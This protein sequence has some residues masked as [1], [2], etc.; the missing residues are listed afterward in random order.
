MQSLLKLTREDVQRSKLFSSLLLD[1]ELDDLEKQFGI[2]NIYKVILGFGEKHFRY[3]YELINKRQD[4][5]GEVAL[6]VQNN[7][8]QVLLHTKDHYPEGVYRIP[9]GGINF[10]EKVIDALHREIFEETGFKILSSKFLALLLYEFRYRGEAIPF[11][12]FLFKVKPNGVNPRVQDE[13]EKISDFRWIEQSRVGE[14]AAELR[15]LPEA[16]EEWGVM[17]AI[18][19]EIVR[20][21]AL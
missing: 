12:S 16:W 2:L 17:R 18:P 9:T 11:I 21:L 4:R 14:I 1:G 3:W 6:I 19:H 5:R 8:N 15:N 10:G 20:D 13:N 7:K